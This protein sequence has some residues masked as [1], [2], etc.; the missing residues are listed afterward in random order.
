MAR[1]WLTVTAVLIAA[2][3]AFYQFTLQPILLATGIIGRVV[4]SVGNTQ[5]TG[6][7]E[8]QACEKLILHDGLLY[9]ACSTPESRK[10]WTPS[11]WPLNATG[12]STADYF[13]TY[14]PSTKQTT[15]LAFANFDTARGY[16]SHGFDVVTSAADKNELFVY[17]VNHRPPL[18]ASAFE[19]GADSVIEVF[20]MARGGSVLTH[21]KTYEDEKIIEPNDVV[22]F[23]DGKSFY[24]TNDKGAKTGYTRE[25]E[26]LGLKRS[27]VVYCHADQGCKY[28][29]TGL[30]DTNG[31]TRAPN[32]TY[33]VAD[34]QFGGV[35]VLERQADNSLVVL[36]HIKT[37]RGIDNVAV[38]DNG[39]VW[40][41][42]FPKAL[43]FVHACAHPERGDR[44]PSSA[45]R[46]TLNQ[47]E[48]A[49]FGEK[50]KV[51][52]VFEDDGQIASCTTSAV[53]DVKRGLLYLSGLCSTQLTICKL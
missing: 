39:A 18:G 36:D 21:V 48:G 14:N 41:S 44:A 15:R 13:A 34:A 4:E 25:L 27:S 53:Y 49:F 43:Q 32:D 38:D 1:I 3:A 40:G 50:Y 12:V 52:K 20:K 35:R 17:A 11:L 29:I 31:I 26:W 28:A 51:E 10:H 46:I 47:G 6:V 8:F 7:P 24:F 19:V 2:L 22:G 45:I 42:G 5:C 9:L 23:G 37:D 30:P 16:S 33:Y